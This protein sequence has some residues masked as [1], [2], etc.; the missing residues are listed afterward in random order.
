MR[1]QKI[2][3]FNFRSVEDLT[4]DLTADGLHALIGPFGSGKSSFLTGV[5]FALFGDNGEAGANLDLRRRDADDNS[6]AGCEV[7]F[8]HGQDIY[9][10]RRWLRRS[11]TKNGP[12]EKAQASL[13]I[14]G[15]V[16]D[17][18]S[19][20]TLTQEMEQTLG[21]TARAY[22]SAS[23][24]PQGE[25][26]TL[27]KAPP[28]EVQALIEEHTGLDAL[29]K[30]RDL[31]RKNARETDIAAQALPGDEEA[32]VD[33]ENQAIDAAAEV[34]KAD[35]A[36]ATQQQRATAATEEATQADTHL[37]ELRE[38]ERRAAAHATRRATTRSRAEDAHA[39]LDQM[40][41]EAVEAGVDL[42]SAPAHDTAVFAQVSQ[43]MEAVADA[44]RALSSTRA[45]V[46]ECSVEVDHAARQAA[47][48]TTAVTE[49]E[50]Q[51][52]DLNAAERAAYQAR[53]AS[54]ADLRS[55]HSEYGIA[56]AE[57][58]RLAKAI[59]TLRGDAGSGHQCPTCRQDVVDHQA[60][61]TDLEELHRM[62]REQMDAATRA[63]QAARQALTNADGALTAVAHTRQH[64]DKLR[65]QQ[66]QAQTALEQAQQ[67]YN[68]AVVAEKQAYEALH[69]LVFEWGEGVAEGIDNDALLGLGRDLHHQLNKRRD[70]M[71]RVAGLRQRIEQA[72]SKATVAAAAA[73]EA[74]ATT[75]AAPT[76]EEVADADR[77]ARQLRADAD[78]AAAA[79]NEAT[80]T[81]AAAKSA[82]GMV[83][84]Q[85]EAARYEWAAKCA[86]VEDATVARAEADVLTAFRSDLLADYTRS[87]CRAASDLLAGFGGEFVAFHLGDDFIPRAE[88]ADGTLVRTS[89]LSGGEAALVGLGFRIGV[90]LCITGGGMPEQIMGDEITSY[91]DDEGRRTVVAALTRIFPS[92]L[93][94]SHTAEAEDYAT[95]VHR[96]TR[97]ELRP[98][99][100]VDSEQT[101]RADEGEGAAAA[102]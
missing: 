48:A 66:Q 27:M 76:A 42:D 34:A 11:N 17:G 28:A 31:A 63:G 87:I 70:V 40:I 98:T 45:R 2:H 38:Q 67:R 56:E 46:G 14:N 44:G 77:R 78:A 59:A 68:S 25:V 43:Q 75:V 18:I 92:V 58:K 84:M 81:H 64:L 6:D 99:R 9:V 7:T 1:I 93:I 83:N 54:D 15:N 79:L 19:P 74:A 20:R 5:R 35:E 53:D 33:L 94:V 85:L 91:L 82:Q 16:I 71:V 88:L 89:I 36:L 21:M 61:I 86:A 100:F 10:V 30:K 50:R 55:S 65:S 3:L 12:V 22:T 57:S 26:A 90:T 41:Q 32:L 24:I 47:K 97:S 72:R 52:G 29:T 37:R 51:A 62:A 60:L 102:A 23:L 96:V 39:N 101:H 49:T 95:E 69:R 73:Q 80:R 8:T 13:T 4:L